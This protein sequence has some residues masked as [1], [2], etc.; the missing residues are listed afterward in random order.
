MYS[1]W[2]TST[3]LLLNFN[4]ILVSLYYLCDFPLKQHQPSYTAYNIIS[5]SPF[6]T[7]YHHIHLYV[8]A[9]NGY[10][11]M[12]YHKYIGYMCLLCCTPPHQMLT[13][14][15]ILLQT[16]LILLPP[17]SPQGCSHADSAIFSP[18]GLFT[19]H[20]KFECEEIWRN[21]HLMQ[22][23]LN[24][25]ATPANTCFVLQLSWTLRYLS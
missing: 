8:N 12:K 19:Y 20:I 3:W 15:P 16:L 17:C 4:V 2:D 5:I 23:D 9:I 24:H 18:Q 13:F 21:V 11:R 1:L 10:V 14:L 22:T 25:N 7:K 6:T